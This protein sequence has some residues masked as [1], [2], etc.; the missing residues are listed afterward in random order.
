MSRLDQYSVTVS[1]DGANLGTF[2]KMTG[3]TADSEDA[4]YRPG[5]M[6]DE[7]ALGGPAT[8]ENVTVTRRYL[9]ERD[10][11]LFVTLRNARGRGRVVVRRQPLDADR[12]PYGDP[13]V[14]TGIL[15]AVK[16]PEPDSMSGDAAMLELEVSTDGAIG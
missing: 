6:G 13:A 15:K 4:K 14:F 1:L 2:D 5:A 3:G 10:H 16:A 12:N 9:L 8:T 11:A 7:I